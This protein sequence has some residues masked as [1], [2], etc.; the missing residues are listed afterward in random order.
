MKQKRETTEKLVLGAI[1]TA[2]VVILQLMGSFIRFGP[3]SISLV[4]IPIVLGAATCG[5]SVS[6]WLGFV[7]G[8]VVLFMDAGAFLAISVPGTIITVLL[9]GMACGF[10]AGLTYE[11]LEKVNRYLAV[12]VAAIVCPIVNTGVFVLGCFTFFM[13]ALKEWGAGAGYDN[14]FAYVFIGMIGINFIAEL[15]SNILL[16]PGIVRLLN[17]RKKDI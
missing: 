8:V 14:V 17:I 10:L 7:F 1:L 4:L 13:D 16:S 5:K 3:F 9:K 15:V 6:T 11:L 2:L 12:A